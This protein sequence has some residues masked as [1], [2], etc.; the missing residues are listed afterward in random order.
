MSAAR[1]K[2]ADYPFT[3]LYPN[4][5]V[6]RVSN[7]RSFVVAD[8][9]GLIEGAAEGAG[10]GVR[11]LKHISRTRLLYHVVDVAPA[12][13]SDPVAS[14]KVI[15]DELVKYSDE[16]AVKERWLVL[17]KVDLLPPDEV[18][19]RCDEIIKQLNWQG[20]VFLVS[21]ATKQGLDLLANASMKHL[22]AANSAEE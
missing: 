3:T 14:V 7:F 11:F 10:L 20:R 1:P 15:A 12:D 17:N 9:P 19:Q 5:G 16:L 22:D 21:G 6:V 18:T 8:L 13:E 2:V 4:L